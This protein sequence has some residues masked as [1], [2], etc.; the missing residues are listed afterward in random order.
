MPAAAQFWI[1][2][3]GRAVICKLAHDKRFDELSLG[4]LLTMEMFER[5]LT[6]DRPREISLGRGDDPY[7]KL[8]L[9]KRRERWGITAANPR[10]WRGLR[11]GLKRRA[12]MIYHRL[13]REPARPGS[14]ET[15]SA[16]IAVSWL[17]YSSLIPPNLFI[18][19]AMIGVLIAWRRKAFRAGGG[20]RRDR[21]SLSGCDAGRGR[22]PDP[23]GGGDRSAEPTLPPDKPPGAIVVLSADARRSDVPGE[24]DTVGPLTL[25]RLAEAA[26]Q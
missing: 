12:A 21:L 18:L 2:W 17:S 10:T 4:T 5:V 19:L 13:R 22:S 16:R 11:L 23:I 25:E 26:R 8:W 24:P 7:K 1:V 15:G 3:N 9:P 14:A 20:D 6:E